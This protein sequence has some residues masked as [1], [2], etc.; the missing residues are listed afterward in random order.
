MELKLL[1]INIL[2]GFFVIYGYFKYLGGALK[3]GITSDQLWANIRGNYRNLYYISMLLSTLSY[4]YLLYYFV[5]ITKENNN[6][7]YIGTLIF[8]IGANLWAPTLFHHLINNQ[9]K[10]FIY[11]SLCLTTIGIILLFIHLMNK[12][13]LISKICISIFLFHILILD[14]LIWSIKFQKI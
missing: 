8:F 11:I 13:N 14:N 4:L 12:G 5:F 10:V 2:L 7:V 6:I 1:F 3:K 9:E